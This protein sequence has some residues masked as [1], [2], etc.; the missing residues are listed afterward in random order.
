MPQ[1]RCIITGKLTIYM[2]EDLPMKK[3][4]AMLLMLAMLFTVT[5]QAEDAYMRQI[6]Q[7][8]Y[9]NT[10]FI[11]P[12]T[13]PQVCLAANY[14]ESQYSSSYNP[15][16][17]LFVSFNLPEGAV[18]ASFDLNTCFLLDE[19]EN[20]QYNYQLMENYSYETMLNKCNNDA[21]IIFDGT[22]KKAAY[23]APDSAR[24]YG[25]IG[26]PEIAKGAKLYITIY[27]G[28]LG[29]NITTEER[30][31]LLTDAI[32]NEVNRVQAE[33]KVQRLDPH[34]STGRYTGLKMPSL[35]YGDQM[36]VFDFPEVTMNCK[37]GAAATTRM[38]PISLDDNRFSC[39]AIFDKESGL[40]LEVAMET[41]SYVANKKEDI[42][43]EIHSVTLSNGLVFDVY[44]PGLAEYGSST[45]AYASYL[46]ADDA[47]YKHDQKY[48]LNLEFDGNGVSWTSVEE[49]T[50]LLNSIMSNMYFANPADDPYVP[51]PAAT[52]APAAPAA[53]DAP[54]AAGEANGWACPECKAEN[55]GNFCTNCGTKKPAD[56]GNWA[57]P[58]CKTENAGNFCSNCGTKKP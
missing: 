16:E 46:L 38:F 15:K 45:I 28:G 18:A 22:D 52:D 43:K 30:V 7:K 27:L 25:L 55:N 37:N 31:K 11:V 12:E 20:I 49:M 2:K 50:A 56:N 8:S 54:E 4:L 42:P 10:L 41:Y 5:A 53:N 51:A 6:N 21:Y 14:P 47:G 36:L 13:Y 9:V 58:S 29:R 24:A 26:V 35:E 3:F 40:E 23:L 57:C 32:T 44:I 19:N 34:W 48:Y 39:Y 33:L 17:P 1:C